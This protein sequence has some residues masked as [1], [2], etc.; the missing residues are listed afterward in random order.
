[1]FFVTIKG[2]GTVFQI[3]CKATCAIEPK[4]SK[5]ANLEILARIDEH[6]CYSEDAHHHYARMHVAV[7]P[8]CNIQCNYCIRRYDCANENR[9]GV[10]SERHTPQE[11]F[12]RVSAVLEKIPKTTVVGIAGPGDPLANPQKTFRTFELIRDNFPDVHLC[13]STNGLALPSYID[14]ITNLGIEHVTVTVNTIDP[15]IGVKIYPWVRFEGQ[16]YRGFKA[17]EILISRQQEGIEK[18]AN[19]NVLI[20]INTVM[21]PEINDDHI[22]KIAHKVHNL[23]AFIINIIPFI[24]IEGTPFQHKRSPT[25]ME[26]RSIQEKCDVE[27]RVMRHCRQCRAD[28]VGLL[29][30]DRATEFTKEKISAAG[31]TFPD[32]DYRQQILEVTSELVATQQQIRKDVVAP[33]ISLNAEMLFAVCSK[34]ERIINQHFGDTSE[35]LIY[36]LDKTGINFVES[37]NVDR[38]C[39]GPINCGDK[40]KMDLIIEILDDCEAVLA[41]NFGLA[42][43]HELRAAGITPIVTGDIIDR[44]IADAATMP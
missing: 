37:R 9:P 26:R 17:S 15:E 38:Y 14:E 3:G 44:A 42:P 21:I 10:T 27:L 39:N 30:E 28:A 16:T 2:Y 25:L 4:N 34:G 29:G 33:S 35:F 23:G 40:E 43:E 5:R 36:K 22:P 6:P 41:S 13:L 1:V 32:L 31:Q 19:R 18:F 11:A 7:A 24:P 20:K 12:A 8:R